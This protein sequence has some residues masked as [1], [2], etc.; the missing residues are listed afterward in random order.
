MNAAR[1]IRLA[2]GVCGHMP[3]RHVVE[4]AADLALMMSAQMTALMIEDG[5]SESLGS[6][7]FA[8]EYMVARAGWSEIGANDVTSR[9]DSARRRAQVLF[10]EIAASAGVQT[11]VQ[12]LAGAAV[13][14][15]ARAIADFDIV[16]LPAPEL[17]GEWMM[18]P[19]SSLVEAAI[20][21]KSAAVIVPSLVSR[22]SGPVAAIVDPQDDKALELAGRMARTSGESLVVLAAGFEN[23]ARDIEHIAQQ[24]GV[25]ARQLRVLD[26]DD[27]SLE[28]I[29]W[30]LGA[31]NERTIV[32]GRNFLADGG[33]EI[34]LRLATS[35]G[36]PVMLPGEA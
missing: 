8:R 14:E 30:T 25:P 27:A 13:G 5:A 15:I 1:S 24:A 7:P 21:A 3:K 23:V 19:F 35:R 36:V 11:S 12:T 33:F 16:A 22:R 18:L 9:R 10:D 32:L 34:V 4:I 29:M 17:A 28:V 31:I 20:H 2:V 6:I 26:I